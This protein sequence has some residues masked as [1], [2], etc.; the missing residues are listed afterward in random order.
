VEAERKAL[1]A[2][3]DFGEKAFLHEILGP[4]ALTARREAFDDCV[5][6]DLG[7][8]VG[9]AEMPYLVYSLDHPSFVRHAAETVSPY[10]FYGRWLAAVT[11]ND[12]VAM[13]ARCR[14]FALDLAAPLKTPIA[15]VAELVAGIREILDDYGAVYEGGN[16]DAGALE[17]V[18]FC[19][20]VVPRHALVRRAGARPGDYIAVTGILGQGWVEY[21]VRK[22]G[23][24]GAIDQAAAEVLRRYK[25]MPVAAHAAIARA[26][27]AGCLSSGMD[28]SDGLIEFLYTIVNRNGCGAVIEVE[29]LPVSAATVACLPVI[30]DATGTPPILVEHPGTAALE[31]GYDSPLVHAFTVPRNRWDLAQ[32]IFAELGR[33]LHRIGTVVAQPGARLSIGGQEITVPEFWDDQCRSG[34]LVAAW[35]ELLDALSAQRTI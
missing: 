33:T 5:V 19:W 34:S 27:E 20:G 26:A 9:G 23:L 11:C 32:R 21:L 12:V 16:F 28:L 2:I 1:A 22:G 8:L 29:R 25:E 6:I 15:D 35:V 7:E 31:A 18:G 24:Y 4:A 14:G 30:A 3:C 17:T 13:G 10:R